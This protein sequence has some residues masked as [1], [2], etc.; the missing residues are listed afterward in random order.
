MSLCGLVSVSNKPEDKMRKLP[1]YD[2]LSEIMS[3][4]LAIF[5]SNKKC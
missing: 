5:V 1:S 3:S 4:D 2:E